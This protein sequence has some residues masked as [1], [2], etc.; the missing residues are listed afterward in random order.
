M[1][2]SIFNKNKQ[3]SFAFVE[4]QNTQNNV[5]ELDEFVNSGRGQTKKVLNPKGR[6]KL[7]DDEL[8]HEQIIVYLT[9]EQ[10]DEITKRAKQSSL[11]VS[12]YVMLKVFGIN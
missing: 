9:K 2:E 3:K 5:N 1:K 10:K 6:P 12:K 4:D 7:N 11:S 8:K